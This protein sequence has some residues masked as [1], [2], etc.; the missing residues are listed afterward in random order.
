MIA[1]LLA[2]LL[3]ASGDREGEAL[4]AVIARSRETACRS[5]KARACD[6]LTAFEKGK[7]ASG[8]KPLLS[9]GALEVLEVRGGKVVSP[10]AAMV[11]SLDDAGAAAVFR[12][13]PE[14]EKEKAELAAFVKGFAAGK[15]DRRSELHGLMQSGAKGQPRYRTEQRD[16]SLAFQVDGLAGGHWLRAVGKKLYLVGFGGSLESPALF[17]SELR[18]P[19]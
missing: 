15:A 9:I 8:A 4:T 12:I 14:N 2:A 13:T 5:P 11:L 10:D 1:L 16:G 7:P 17:I 6:W 19:R 18:D 3:Q